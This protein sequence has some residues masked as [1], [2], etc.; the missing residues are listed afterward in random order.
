MVL[1]SSFNSLTPFIGLVTALA[2][3]A[4]AVS[5]MVDAGKTKPPTQKETGDFMFGFAFIIA[6]LI[7]MLNVRDAWFK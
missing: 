4:Y 2:L 1:L 5:I 7:V 6:A 3:F